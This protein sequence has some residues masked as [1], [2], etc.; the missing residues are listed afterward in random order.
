[1]RGYSIPTLGD[2]FHSLCRRAC[3]GEIRRRLAALDPRWIYGRSR[4]PDRACKGGW[5]HLS[6]VGGCR[7]NALGRTVPHLRQPPR[8]RTDQVAPTRR[9]AAG[10]SHVVGHVGSFTI[11]ASPEMRRETWNATPATTTFNVRSR[12]LSPAHALSC[13]DTPCQGSSDRLD[14]SPDQVTPSHAPVRRQIRQLAH[15]GL[16]ADEPR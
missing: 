8:T 1:M 10:S 13:G 16:M 11:R 14:P 2:T 9:P 4:R 12:R 3:A 6:E 15:T 5:P 7:S